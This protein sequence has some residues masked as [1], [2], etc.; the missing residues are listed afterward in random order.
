MPPY[1]DEV[2]AERAS[3]FS[4]RVQILALEVLDHRQLADAL[5]VEVEDPRGDLVELGLDAGAEPAFAGDQLVA[6]ADC[7]DENRLEHAVLAERVGQ[8]GDLGRVELAARLERVRVDL[9]DGDLDQLGAVERARLETAFLA[10]RAGLPGRGRV[11]AY[12][13][14]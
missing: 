11:V 2:V 1:R 9:I 8:G 7:A 10:A 6:V 13:R 5:V 4:M 12:S 3:A 14:R